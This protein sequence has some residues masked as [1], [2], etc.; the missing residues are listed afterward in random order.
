MNVPDLEQAIRRA[1]YLY[2]NKPEEVVLADGQF[3]AMMREL[4]ERNPDSP[5]LG[6]VGATTIEGKIR[7]FK[8][9]Y[10]LDN[11]MNV[12][13]A[14]KFCSKMGF[15]DFIV[16]Q[17][18]DGASV[19]LIYWDGRLHSASTRGDGW[20]GDEIPHIVHIAPQ[21]LRHKPPKILAVYGEVVI[22]QIAF[23]GLGN[24]YSSPRNLA[25]GSLMTKD[26][27]D[28]LIERGAKFLA[29]D[30]SGPGDHGAHLAELEDYGFTTVPYMVVRGWT[31]VESAYRTLYK[32][33]DEFYKCYGPSDGVVVRVDKKEIAYD[34]S[35]GNK[36]PNFAVAWKFPHDGS[37]HSISKT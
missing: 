16:S 8:K 12:V 32:M 1:I 5:I 11:A 13:E 35:Y 33:R 28:V 24:G 23:E 15:I 31:G 36:S 19:E 10:S 25:A 34:W 9:I 7:H 21:E 37:F 3:D 30:M 26:N 29:F 6:E 4:W 27:P 22:N 17:K 14:Q 18:M 20:W 2:H